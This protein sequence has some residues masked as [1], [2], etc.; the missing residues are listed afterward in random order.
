M[1]MVEYSHRSNSYSHTEETRVD[2]D[3][4]RANTKW[5]GDR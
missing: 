3:A 1:I 2:F 4:V 5:G